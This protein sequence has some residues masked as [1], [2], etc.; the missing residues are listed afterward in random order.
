[1]EGDGKF[2]AL[3]CDHVMKHPQKSE[4]IHP[5]RDDYLNY[6]NYHLQQ[7]MERIQYINK[8]KQCFLTETISQVS[9]GVIKDLER[10]KIKCQELKSLKEEH[11]DQD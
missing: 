6:L 5:A 8:R 10:L 2:Y 11:Y 4:I 9:F 1:M 3:S 7:Y